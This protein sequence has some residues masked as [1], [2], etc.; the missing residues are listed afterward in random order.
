MTETLPRVLARRATEAGAEL[1]LELQPELLWFRGHFP[2]TPI[3]PGVVQIHWALHFAAEALG[4]GVAAATDFQ[5]KFKAI[6][7]PGDRPS[8]ALALG[9]AGRHLDFT[10]RRGE[11]VFSTGRIRL[12]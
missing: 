12:P 8:L 5:V 4:L 11:Q 1:E 6:L 10:Y 3:L 2:G 7:S 9:P